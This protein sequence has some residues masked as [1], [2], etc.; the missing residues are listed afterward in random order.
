MPTGLPKILYES[1]FMDAVP[2]ASSTAAGNFNVLNLRDFRPYTQWKPAAMPATVTV[3]S[4]AAKS[5]DY[6]AVYG[7]DLFTQGATLEVRRSTDN[8]AAN[9][10]L[11]ATILP[12]SNDPFILQFASV[13][14]RYWRIKVTGATAPSL[15]I[16]ALGVAL[17]MP[18][19]LREGFDPVGRVV[20]G[21]YNQSVKGHPLGRAVLYE[22]WSEA[23][24]FKNLTWTFIRTSWLAAWRAHLR[25]NPWIFVW[26]PTDH[27]SEIFLVAAKDQFKTPHHVGEFADLSLDVMGV[28]A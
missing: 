7:H 16:A 8:F 22:E 25:G 4:G 12:A 23:L 14:F 26:D 9:D 5:A 27:A 3:D 10:V 6:C 21:Q 18:R 1:R 15:A 13:S 24:Q 11:V 20:K 28:A 2:V 19:R 17:E